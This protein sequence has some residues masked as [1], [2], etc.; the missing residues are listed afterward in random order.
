MNKKQKILIGFTSLRKT[1]FSFTMVMFLLGLCLL[2]SCASYQMNGQFA[3]TNIPITEQSVLNIDPFQH[4]YVKEIDGRTLNLQYMIDSAVLTPGEHLIT[5]QYRRVESTNAFSV[6]VTGTDN[7][8]R[9][10]IIEG[11]NVFTFPFNFLP[12][13]Y[14][15]VAAIDSLVSVNLPNNTIA[16]AVIDFTDDMRVVWCTHDAVADEILTNFRRSGGSMNRSQIDRNIKS[17]KGFY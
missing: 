3:D 7:T 5:V 15:V 8:L 13:R 9:S 14:Y 6:Y 11:V 4:I 17:R 2:N 10:T 16:Y 12:G 1:L